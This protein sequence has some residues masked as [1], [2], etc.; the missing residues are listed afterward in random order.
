[1][2][3]S[4][5]HRDFQLY[6]LSVKIAFSVKFCERNL[7]HNPRPLFNFAVDSQHPARVEM[8]RASAKGDGALSCLHS[9]VK[10]Y[11]REMNETPGP[12]Q[13]YA[14]RVHGRPTDWEWVCFLTPRVISL[15]KY[16]KARCLNFN[17]SSQPLPLTRS[18]SRTAHETLSSE[19][20]PGAFAFD[21]FT[22]S[23]Q[24]SQIK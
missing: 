2:I 21:C 17:S 14:V 12:W 9:A 7:F 18:A 24:Q 6:E 3:N 8:N 23:S 15:T 16:N 19:K 11:T 20:L 22:H 13:D 1:M 10:I 5:L 4:F